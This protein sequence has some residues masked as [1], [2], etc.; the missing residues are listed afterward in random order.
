MF[1][2]VL[3]QAAVP[4]ILEQTDESFFKKTL[5]L[6][7]NSSDICCDWIKEI[8]CIDSSHRPEG[9]M[10]MMVSIILKNVHKLLHILNYGL[11]YLICVLRSG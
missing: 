6:L 4:T 2:I 10:A 9:S 11:I 3:H 7:K 5:N 1:L 8:P